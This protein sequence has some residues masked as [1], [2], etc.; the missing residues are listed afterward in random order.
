MI[1]CEVFAG[2]H[3]FEMVRRIELINGYNY[4]DSKKE[5]VRC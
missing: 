2:T 1:N 4:F 5:I 3:L